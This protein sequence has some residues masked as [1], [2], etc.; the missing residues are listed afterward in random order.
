MS[1][2]RVKNVAKG[3][4]IA[5]IAI[6]G[7]YFL[8]CTYVTDGGR[9]V[10]GALIVLASSGAAYPLVGNS[11]PLF[12]SENDTLQA[13]GDFFDRPP[14]LTDGKR[15]RAYILLGIGVYQIVK[16]TAIA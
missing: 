11:G 15:Q 4:A 6:L 3:I 10:I 2:Q 1:K 9:F 8:I 16:A 12:E 5:S 13:I 14:S 7:Y